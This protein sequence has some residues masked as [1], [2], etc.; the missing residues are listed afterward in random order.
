MTLCLERR[1]E[2][3]ASSHEHNSASSFRNEG[4]E[5]KGKKNFSSEETYGVKMSLCTTLNLLNR[6]CAPEI[7]SFLVL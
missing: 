4:M 3:C 6:P 1:Q 7:L 2:F 5:D